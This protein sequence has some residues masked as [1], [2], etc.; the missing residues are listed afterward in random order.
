MEQ[1]GLMS[2]IS[3]RNESILK[4]KSVVYIYSYKNITVPTSDHKIG[5]NIKKILWIIYE[6][7]GHVAA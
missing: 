1:K 4:M 5:R 6:K 7:F 2:L 3:H